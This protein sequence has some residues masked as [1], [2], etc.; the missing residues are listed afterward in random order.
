MTFGPRG[1][2]LRVVSARRAH[3]RTVMA[4]EVPMA[5][6]QRHLDVCAGVCVC[7]C[8]HVHEQVNV[9]CLA[10]GSNSVLCLDFG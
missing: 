4:S 7:V 1:L 3:V 5:S 10:K 2:C 6:G 9:S 8:V